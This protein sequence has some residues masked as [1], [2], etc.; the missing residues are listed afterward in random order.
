MNTFVNVNEVING[1]TVTLKIRGV[2]AFRW[3]LRILVWMVVGTIR[4]L[5]LSKK[6][7]VELIDQEDGKE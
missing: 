3:K 6:I 7:R 2:I 5:G 1:M 4:L